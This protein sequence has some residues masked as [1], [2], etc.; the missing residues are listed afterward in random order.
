MTLD[1]DRLAAALGRVGHDEALHRWCKDVDGCGLYSDG[2]EFSASIAREYER[3][4]TDQPTAHAN[5]GPVPGRP[6]GVEPSAG[7]PRLDVER[8]AR[9]LEAIWP[10]E[11]DADYFTEK[12]RVFVREYE[13]PRAR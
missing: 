13:S 6:V 8:V 7:V 12:A 11:D 9:E 1:V 5:T 10:Y 4:G 3:L 2:R